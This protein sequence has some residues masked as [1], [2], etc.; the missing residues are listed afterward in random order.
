MTITE[1]LLARIADD[2]EVARRFRAGWIAAGVPA[3]DLDLDFDTYSSHEY[4]EIG[5]GLGRWLAECK[6]RRRIVE[7]HEIDGPGAG[8]CEIC[9]DRDYVGLVD[10][11]PCDTL[12]ALASVYADHP[13]FQDEWRIA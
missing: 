10:E 3:D 9:T 7:L 5:L 6:A 8:S 1:F 2:E 12:K 11:G 4:T 13:D